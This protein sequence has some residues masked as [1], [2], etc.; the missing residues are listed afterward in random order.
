[1]V[2][3]KLVFKK[4]VSKDLRN[5]PKKDVARIVAGFDKISEDPRGPGCEKLTGRDSYRYRV[6]AYR[7]LYEIRDRVLVVSVIKVGQR[8]E[9]YR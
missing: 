3:Y 4:S 5:V 8:R 7:I 2:K 6:G 1:M 9:A